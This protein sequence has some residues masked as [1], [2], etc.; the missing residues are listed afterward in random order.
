[1]KAIIWFTGT[2]PQQTCCGVLLDMKYVRLDCMQSQEF[3]TQIRT[4]CG[5]QKVDPYGKISLKGR[6]KVVLDGKIGL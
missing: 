4:E 5:H 6:W 3:R 2:D 1:M